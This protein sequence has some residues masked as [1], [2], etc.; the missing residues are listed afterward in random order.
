MGSTSVIEHVAIGTGFDGFADPPDDLKDAW[1]LERL[2]QRLMAEGYSEEQIGKIW[3]DN[4][5]R[6]LKE[7]WG[8]KKGVREGRYDQGADPPAKRVTTP[9]S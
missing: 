6:V 7:G 5:L 1:E 4:A 3:G 2:T 9:R 8:K